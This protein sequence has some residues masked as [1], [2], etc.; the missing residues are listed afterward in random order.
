MEPRSGL[1]AQQGGHKAGECSQRCLCPLCCAFVLLTVFLDA[2]QEA[3]RVGA[4]P[5]RVYSNSRLG[6]PRGTRPAL[7]RALLRS[8]Y[9]RRISIA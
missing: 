2:K 6:A 4:P 7:A 5:L 1:V 9:N 8:K 3:F